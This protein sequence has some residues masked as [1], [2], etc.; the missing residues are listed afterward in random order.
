MA[1]QLVVAMTVTDTRVRLISG[2]GLRSNYCSPSGKTPSI[3]NFRRYRYQFVKGVS[4]FSTYIL[5]LPVGKPVSQSLVSCGTDTQI[6]LTSNV[7]FCPRVVIFPQLSGVFDSVNHF[8]PLKSLSW[9]HYS[10]LVLLLPPCPHFLLAF[11]SISPFFILCS[12]TVSYLSYFDCV[13]RFTYH[14]YS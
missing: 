2:F 11:L 6:K 10:C 4:R 8:L 7:A 9:L 1:Y 14:F 13:P 5:I 3:A 12:F